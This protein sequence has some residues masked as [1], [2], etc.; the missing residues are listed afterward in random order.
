[1]VDSNTDIRVRGTI[2]TQDMENSKAT[3]ML[4]GMD[5]APM[6]A[7][8]GTVKRRQVAT[9]VSISQAKGKG[10][11]MVIL[12]RVITAENVKSDW[13]AVGSRQQASLHCL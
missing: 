2:S 1:M 10:K 13:L 5:K 7:A 11:V 6:R 9:R 3:D 4:V 12:A 8:G